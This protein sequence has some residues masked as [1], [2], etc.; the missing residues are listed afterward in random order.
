M[1]GAMRSTIECA[2]V[3]PRRAAPTAYGNRHKPR[4]LSSR[5]HRGNW[6]PEVVS[7]VI[8]RGHAHVRGRERRQ[9]GEAGVVVEVDAEQLPRHRL[10][11][12]AVDA[13]KTLPFGAD[14]L[15]AGQELF[16]RAFDRAPL[17]PSRRDPSAAQVGDG[18]RAKVAHLG[19]D[20]LLLGGA[21]ITTEVAATPPC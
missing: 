21:L 20:L 14:D 6:H 11:G 3:R 15:A 8:V 2:R 19:K 7:K 17:P 10:L 12:E 16:H 5:S 13:S 9:S 18:D 4:S 1:P